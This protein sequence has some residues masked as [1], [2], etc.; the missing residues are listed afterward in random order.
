[1]ITNKHN[2]ITCGKIIIKLV[3]FYSILSFSNT[4]WGWGIDTHFLIN[5]DS[6]IHLPVGMSNFT[7]YDDFLANHSIDA[8]LRKSIDPN[9]APRHYMDIDNFSGF[10]DGT[11]PHDLDL[12]IAEYGSQFDVIDNGIVPFAIELFT[13][14]LRKKMAEG[15]WLDALLLAADLGHYVA[16]AHQPLHTTKNY[17]GQLTGN[18]GIHARYE[19]EMMNRHL[20]AITIISNQAIYITNPI[21]YAFQIIEEAWVFVDSI[22]LADEIAKSESGGVYDDIYY[23]ALWRETGDFS[24][25][26]IRLATEALA[27][28]WYTAWVNAGMPEIPSNVFSSVSIKDIQYTIDPSGTS[29]L[30]GEIVTISGIVTAE[31]RGENPANGGISHAYFFISDSTALWSGIQIY[32]SDS[33]VAEG[34][35]ITLTGTVDEYYGETEI[36]D[37]TEFIRHSTR[38]P[39]PGPLEVT[40]AEAGT[41]AYE[42]CLVRVRDATIV[43]TGIVPY[44]NWR[45][46]DGSGAVQID[47]RSKYY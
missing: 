41:E 17:D 40:T 36:K 20:A 33:T 9:E 21:D 28:L 19:T 22:M 15:E 35:S 2:L 14:S 30:N 31:H 1:M 43:E 3:T 46:D 6:E 34:D 16:D 26:Q 27:S 38:N 42:G 8:D 29:P 25:N 13:D 32:Y 7:I 10:F 44:N 24:I 45:V 11:L 18:D 5:K 37:V 12:L 47:M 23:D 4:A 39:L